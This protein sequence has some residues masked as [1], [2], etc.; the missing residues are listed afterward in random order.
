MSLVLHFRVLGL[1]S[2]TNV[3]RLWVLKSNLVSGFVM[4][5]LIRLDIC[6]AVL[7]C[8]C[9]YT[10]RELVCCYII[11]WDRTVTH[12]PHADVVLCVWNVY[13]D[14]MRWSHIAVCL[15]YSV[16]HIHSD[17]FIDLT[18]VLSTHF[19]ARVC[20]TH[21][22]HTNLPHIESIKWCCGSNI[23][24]LP[25]GLTHKQAYDVNASVRLRQGWICCCT[26]SIIERTLY[27]VQPFICLYK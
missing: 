8:A 5:K 16:T 2:Q 6:H 13:E 15:H 12:T 26:V 14:A 10:R 4:I 27:Y 21:N 1:T 25:V 7:T 17:V 18:H 19:V 9:W 11:R 22:S 24:I 20:L 3:G 23:N